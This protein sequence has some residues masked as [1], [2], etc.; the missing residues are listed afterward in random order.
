MYIS[1]G[2]MEN[3]IRPF[4]FEND[5]VLCSEAERSAFLD[6]DSNV[7]DEQVHASLNRIKKQI[8][9]GSH[10]GYTAV[11]NEV[12]VGLILVDVEEGAFFVD[13]LY[14]A[15]DHRRKGVGEALMRHVLQELQKHNVEEVD[16]MTYRFADGL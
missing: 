2:K 11:E 6:T 15:P 14:V 13:N 9:R 12:P 7:S 10:W 4:S 8:T 16:Y 1:E 5:E 3:E